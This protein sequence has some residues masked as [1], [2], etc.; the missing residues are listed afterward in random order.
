MDFSWPA[1]IV[2]AG[3]SGGI[4]YLPVLLVKKKATNV[5][6]KELNELVEKISA[7]DKAI[8]E[9]IRNPEEF[10]SVGELDYVNGQLEEARKSIEHE[11]QH[12]REV[13]EK[14]EIC[15]K[16]VE[17]KESQQQEMK[18]AKEEDE[19]KLAE[20]LENYEQISSES[21]LLEQNLA[22][23]L[24][25]LDNLMEELEL[26]AQ[27]KAILQNLSDALT[28]AGG[29]LREL[30]GEYD[31]INERLTN[32]RSQ[33]DDLEGEYTKLVERHLGA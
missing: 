12:L 21:I 15:Q 13:E 23:S 10:A 26:T 19:R 16:D 8:E 25:D 3:L 22:N 17:A 9:L 33:H 31:S 7:K 11:K 5:G 2:T 1:A 24:K 18:S 29:R 14:L 4:I 28:S 30:L 32:L 20:L 6:G 27:Q